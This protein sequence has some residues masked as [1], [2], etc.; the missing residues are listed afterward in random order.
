MTKLQKRNAPSAERNKVPIGTQLATILPQNAQVLEI[1]SGTGQH[2]AYFAGLRPDII[3][4]YTDID[5]DA[6]ESQK[7]YASENTDVNEDIGQLKLPLNL[8]VTK[9][10]WW[11]DLANF[12]NIYCANM[13]HIAPWDA[14]VGL[15]KGAGK[16][17]RAGD[18]L[19]LYGPFLFEQD[20]AQ[21]NLD[22]AENLKQR[23]P[24]WGVRE[25]VDV[26]TLFADNNFH[27]DQQITMPRDNYLLVFHKV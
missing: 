7:A 4:Q 27:L 5:M 16:L 6:L 14:A 11:Q 26:E 25:L 9:E 22:F 8:D 18:K 19:C 1:A 2:G 3:W 23:N 15:A 12:T 13:I 24:E 10:N 17:L 20:S 21:S